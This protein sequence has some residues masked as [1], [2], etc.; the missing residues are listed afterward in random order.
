M[1]TNYTPLSADLFLHPFEYDFMLNTMKQDM[2]KA[3]Q[4]SNN[5]R[6]TDDLLSVNNGEFGDKINTTYPFELEYKETSTSST[7][8][9]YLDARMRLSDNNSPCHVSI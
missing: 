8:V 7:E 9:C 5:F 2:T 6:C 1:G 3:I 4:L